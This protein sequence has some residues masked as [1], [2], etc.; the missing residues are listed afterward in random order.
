MPTAPGMHPV[1]ELR[2][3]VSAS[4]AIAATNRFFHELIG[5]EACEDIAADVA[6]QK[7]KVERTAYTAAIE[8]EEALKLLRDAAADGLNQSDMAAVA[9][10]I[11]HI[12]RSRDRDRAIAEGV[13]L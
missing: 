3:F 2:R 12:E 5:W 9:K 7:E 8:D 11:R 4:K 6:K 13:T 1:T 10:A